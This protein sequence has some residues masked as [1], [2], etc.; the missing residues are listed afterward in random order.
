MRLFSLSILVMALVSMISTSAAAEEPTSVKEPRTGVSFA[1]EHTNGQLL[2]G[3]GCRSKFGFKV[4][5]V[6]LYI[7]P[8]DKDALVA[9]K[10]Q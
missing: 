2:L 10:I 9:A 3:V 8:S 1:K 6:G 7:R 4:Y 5:A